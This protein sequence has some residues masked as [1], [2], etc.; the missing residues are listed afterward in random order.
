M[1]MMFIFERAERAFLSSLLR[2]NLLKL[3][4]D[5][6]IDVIIFSKFAKASASGLPQGSGS[7]SIG[8]YNHGL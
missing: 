4:N 6:R 3:G 1:M 2:L 8:P 5:R 7:Q